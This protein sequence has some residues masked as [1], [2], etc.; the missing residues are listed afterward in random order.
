MRENFRISGML[1]EFAKKSNGID[2]FP[3][4]KSHVEKHMKT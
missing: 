2:I 1:E 4:L 3:K